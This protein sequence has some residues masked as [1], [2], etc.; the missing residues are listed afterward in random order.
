MSVLHTLYI[1]AG[2]A[3]LN[4]CYTNKDCD[5][6]IAWWHMSLVMVRV[7]MPQGAIHIS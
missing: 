7:V 3:T 1:G 2:E 5:D 4:A 6:C